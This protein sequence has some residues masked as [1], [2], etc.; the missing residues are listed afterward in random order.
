MQLHHDFFCPNKNYKSCYL[1]KI[2][3][4]IENVAP[5]QLQESYD[6]A[7]LIIGNAK[8]DINKALICFDV[9]EEVLDEA[10]SIGANLIISHHPI[11]FGGIKKLNGKNYV[12][13]IV[14]KAIKNDIALYAA[15]TNLD[16]VIG[17]Y[18][19]KF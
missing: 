1:G 3:N 15:H 5:L 2:T 10:I 18:Q 19:I 4:V 16:N 13:R 8:M 14:L 6:N 7:G 12:E 17:R 9:T 11:I